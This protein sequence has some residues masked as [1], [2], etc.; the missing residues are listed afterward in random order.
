MIF[1]L[2]AVLFWLAVGVLAAV[3]VMPL[4]SVIDRV[5]ASDEKQTSTRLY[6][7]EARSVRQLPVKSSGA[8]ETARSM[9]TK[10]RTFNVSN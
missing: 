10:E 3:A 5:L 7:T 4:G 6:P 2:A 9:D 8:A 1:F